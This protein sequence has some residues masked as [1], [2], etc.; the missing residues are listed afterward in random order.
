MYLQSAFQEDRAEL[1][2]GLIRVYPL[3]TLIVASGGSVTA[4]PVP[5]ILYPDEGERGVLRAHVARANPVWRVLQEAGECLVV[6]QGANDYISPSWYASKAEH[7]KVVPTWNYSTV[8]VR[9]TARV[10]DDARW[11]RPLLDD[12]TAMH[13]QRLPQPWKLSDAPPAFI[14]TVMQAIIGI[15]LP[16]TSIAGK[17]KTNQN[18]S[19]ADREGV[20]AGLQTQPGGAAMAALVAATLKEA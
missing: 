18:R 1:Q 4:D 8:Q 6:F 7:H 15:E 9:G 14:E 5:F 2:H 20:V 10:M 11:L 16:I 17:W 19:V 3:G 12:L 13:E